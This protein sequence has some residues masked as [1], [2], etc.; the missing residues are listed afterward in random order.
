MT[1]IFLLHFLN[2]RLTIDIRLNFLGTFI[3]IIKL[4]GKQKNEMWVPTGH[5][6]P[7][8]RKYMKKPR[9]VKSESPGFQIN[10]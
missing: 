8:E 4:K 6:I 9:I 10:T 1:E 2:L 7:K 3:T 5:V